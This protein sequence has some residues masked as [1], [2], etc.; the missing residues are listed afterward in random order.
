M[1]HDE[2]A[3]NRGGPPLATQTVSRGR[4]SSSG[5]GDERHRPLH[6][7]TL[8]L[9]RGLHRLSENFV[10]HLERPVPF[11]CSRHTGDLHFGGHAHG[12][13]VGFPL[14]TLGSTV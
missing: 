4:R 8:P 5:F 9:K 3:G 10:A 1:R 13:R 6:D 14:D 11:R 7:V 2:L 12:E